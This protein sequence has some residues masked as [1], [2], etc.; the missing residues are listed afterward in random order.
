MAEICAATVISLPFQPGS[1]LWRRASSKSAGVN[2]KLRPEY[3]F[4]LIPISTKGMF[5]VYCKDVVK[6]YIDVMTLVPL[7]LL[8]LLRRWWRGL[9]PSSPSQEGVYRP[10]LRIC[11][12]VRQAR[13]RC[14]LRDR[15]RVADNW[16]VMAGA[17]GVA[18]LI[19]AVYNET[20]MR[21]SSSSSSS[22]RQIEW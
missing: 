15:A 21:P 22:S 9:P 13:S 7:L 14:R 18:L 19:C 5:A 3:I 12:P 8:L 2:R 6:P 16:S 17:D 10:T 11:R 20:N 4:R 1:S